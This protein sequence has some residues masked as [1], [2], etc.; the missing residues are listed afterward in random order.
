MVKN[1]LPTDKI[2]VDLE[3]LQIDNNDQKKDA[4]RQEIA[5]KYGVPLK[6]VVVNFIPITVNENGDKISLASDIIDN[7]QDP[8]FQK[9]LMKQYIEV[10]EIEDVNFDDIDAIDNQVNAFVD[11]DQYSKYKNYKLKYVKW[12]N[13]LSYGPDNYFDFT[14]LHGMVLLNSEPANQGG[15][16]TFAI[17]LL[18]FALFGKAKKSPTLDSVF[19]IYQPE[20]TEVVVEAGIEI[21]SVDYV[22]RR[23]ITRPA[24]K[25]RTAKSKCKQTVD[26][27]KVINGEFESIENCEG[28]STTQTNNI[29]KESVGN[30]EDFN[31]VIS[32]TAKNLT[33]LIEMGQTDKGRLFSR[34]LG[35]IPIEMKEDIAKNL[36]KKNY[37]TKLLSN[38]YNKE[39]LSG[40]VKDFEEWTK[41]TEKLI[42]ECNSNLEKANTNIEAYNKQK[43]DILTGVRPVKDGLESIDLSTLNMETEKLNEELTNKRAEFSKQKAAYIPLKD[44]VY[45]EDAHKQA[46]VD[47]TKLENEKTE[48]R[49]ENEGIKVKIGQ[50]RNDNTRINNLMA[51]GVCP[52]CGHPVEKA[53]Q[54]KF[55]EK[56]N[57]EIEE[58]KV[59]GVANKA[60][61]DEIDGKIK[62]METKISDFEK[63]KENVNTKTKLELHLTALKTNIENLKLKITANDKTKEE[64]KTNEENIKFNNEVRTKANVVEASIKVETGIR[65]TNIKDIENH[66]T[67]IK[68]NELEIKKRKEIIERLDAEEKIIRNWKIYQELVGKNGI[69]KLVLRKAVPIINNE[70]SRLLHGLCDFEVKLEIDEKNDVVMGLW[71]KGARLD[72]SYCTSGFEGTMAALALR[73]ALAGISSISRPNCLTI[74]E[75][76][77][78]VAAYNYN[79][80]RELFNRITAIYDFVLDITHNE[81]IT[82]WHN[83]V[84][85]V[86]KVDD[87]SRIDDVKKLTL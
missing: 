25:K 23:T 55:L 60:K 44:V 64:I 84:V 31:L 8:K 53:E 71:K 76:F 18:R 37:S 62:D 54:D 51:Q 58:L 9:E 61:M 4:M 17:D 42:A 49:V 10:Y 15:K 14:K 12:S 26:Y 16:T 86:S 6:N 87:I 66:K 85:T 45:D 33:D 70:V 82:D 32:A 30:I 59:K 43:T 68:N 29:I 39:T 5:V 74:D 47:K 13:Y 24:L 81:L 34:W 83:Q 63:A 80:V 69:I 52:N 11:F 22:I 77:G 50:L 72:L 40:E 7:I 48:Y 57:N 79:N 65:D 67:T 36:W 27:Y 20:A 73:A 28:E 56:N 38:T 3:M 21:D 41:E 35:L 78:G 46:I 2:V 19:N 75:C 1:I